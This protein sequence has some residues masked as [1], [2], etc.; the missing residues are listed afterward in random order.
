M[1]TTRSGILFSVTHRGNVP[2]ARD[3]SQSCGKT[4]SR[5]NG[6]PERRQVWREKR[7]QMVLWGVARSHGSA[8]LQGDEHQHWK[9]WWMVEET[10]TGLRCGRC[11][12]PLCSLGFG[13]QAATGSGRTASAHAGVHASVVAAVLFRRQRIN[14]RR[15]LL[16]SSWRCYY[17]L[18]LVSLG[19]VRC[20]S[21]ANIKASLGLRE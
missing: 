3:E 5:S 20:Q 17:L 11:N 18:H 10:L 21:L 12:S 19:S 6:P 15:L 16:V 8:A 4:Q 9:G 2:L 14:M 1:I 13:T 7:Q